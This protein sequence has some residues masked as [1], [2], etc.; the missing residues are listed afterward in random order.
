MRWAQLIG[1]PV[2]QVMAVV[3]GGLGLAGLLA[4]IGKFGVQPSRRSARHA[5]RGHLGQVGDE[6]EAGGADT[7]R[8]STRESVEQPVASESGGAS[9]VVDASV[10]E[11]EVSPEGLTPEPAAADAGTGAAPILDDQRAAESPDDFAALLADQDVAADSAVD[12]PLLDV[13]TGS[14]VE[15][16][17]AGSGGVMDLPPLEPMVDTSSGSGSPAVELPPLTAPV[18]ASAQ[19]PDAAAVA[20]PDLA[21]PTTLGDTGVTNEVELPDLTS[22]EGTTTRP[23]T[24]MMGPMGGGAMGGGSPAPGSGGSSIAPDRAGRQSARDVLDAR[25]GAEKR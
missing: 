10:T 19:V 25:E 18:D 20:L 5:R 11:Q 7:Q 8:G 23:T 12:L 16:A 17:T 13:E 1:V 21:P 4:L 6:P 24:P 22:E 14:G 15:A 2:E 3:E 9:G